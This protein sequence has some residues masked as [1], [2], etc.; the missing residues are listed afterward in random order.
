MNEQVLKDR[1]KR[2]AKDEGKDFGEVWRS[3]VLERF[4]ARISGSEYRERNKRCR[5]SCE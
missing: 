1:I 4:L 2:I 5:L 3:L